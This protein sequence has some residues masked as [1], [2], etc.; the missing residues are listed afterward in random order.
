MSKSRGK[1]YFMEDDSDY[2]DSRDNKKR[3]QDRRKTKK[4]KAALQSK[5]LEYFEKDENV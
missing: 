4:L 2:D 1:K 5:N 3:F